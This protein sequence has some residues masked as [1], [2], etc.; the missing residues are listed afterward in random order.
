VTSRGIEGT[1]AL[2]CRNAE[3]VLVDVDDDLSVVLQTASGVYYEFNHVSRRIWALAARPVS[4]SSLCEALVCEYDVER[5][6]CEA[7]VARFLD[8]L[9]G[10]GLVTFPSALHAA[11]WPAQ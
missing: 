9:A 8:Q 6:R 11:G 5:K 1:D 10:A 4:V 2:V 3:H 7:D